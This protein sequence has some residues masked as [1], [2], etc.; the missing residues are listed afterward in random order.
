MSMLDKLV[1]N[2]RDAFGNLQAGIDVGLLSNIHVP[3]Y[4]ENSKINSG[5]AYVSRKD[6]QYS[7][8]ICE[9]FE[10]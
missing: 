7:Y 3:I 8:F 9:T 5:Q 4:D 2:S 6:E 10:E 1:R